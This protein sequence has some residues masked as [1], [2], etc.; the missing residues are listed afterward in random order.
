[1]KHLLGLP[2]HDGSALF[3]DSTSLALGDRVPVRV[4]VPR[5]YGETEVM[6]R[7]SHDG[8]PLKI[9]A[10]LEREDATERWYTAELPIDNPV[11]NYRWLLGRPG[12]YDW[13]TGRGVMT[14]DVADAGDFRA[15]IYPGAPDWARDAIGYQ[16]F[17]DR[18]ARS[19]ADRIRPDWAEPAAW[20]DEPAKRGR[21][22]VTQWYGGD[23]PGIA[24]RLDYVA[25][26]GVNLLYLTPF[27]PSQ[28]A[29]RYDASTFTHV[30][31]LLGGDDGL[32]ALVRAAHGRRMR[33]IGDL[34]TNHTGDSHEWFIHA[35]DNRGSVEAGFYYWLDQLPPGQRRW[36]E[37]MAEARG[38]TQATYHGR[39]I[40]YVS[41]LGVPSLP[42]LNWGSA[43]LWGRMVTGPESVVARYLAEP[44]GLDG[45]RVDVAHMTGRFAADD[46]HNAVAR[47][48]RAT[49]DA[50]GG[51]LVAEHFYDIFNDVVGDGWQSVMNY[52]AFTKPVWSWLTPA[53]T[54]QQFAD[55][56][57]PVPRRSGGDIVATMREFDA[58][59]PW[60]VFSRQWN[61]LGSH[62]T[63]RVLT[64]LGDPG[65][66]EIAMVWLFTYP[67]LPAFFAGDEGGAVGT[68]GEHSR[69]TMPWDQI[70]AGG[71]V[72]W[73]QA[74]FE[75]Y[76]AA[77]AVRQGSPALKAGSLRWVVTAD[78]AL[79]F[80]RE[81]AEER[82][83]VVLARSPWTG[84]RLPRS[85][86]GDGEPHLLYGGSLVATPALTVTDVLSIDGTGPAVGVWRLA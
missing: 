22:A 45:W 33:V 4:R 66:V 31:P 15:T 84:V 74:T 50:C 52:P 78:D 54:D 59:V 56:P 29:H 25:R 77:I 21:A 67:G 61:M 70:A 10:R 20:D 73:D 71:G 17:P 57:V 6:L 37:T 43:E 32:Q 68:T 40:D 24:E 85:I 44:F 69:V 28:S 82:V 53:D 41:W 23:L 80:L 19:D 18:F 51:L 34:T 13:L 11:V 79:V 63:A 8:D 60:S 5:D 16:I 2:H 1:M 35:Y 86:L 3:V 55:L 81:T 47:A 72:R 30:D 36:A 46:Y 49:V 9:P 76:R 7:A 58:A 42:K 48:M 39:V 12:G 64:L 14:R 26:L 27:F 38:F 65:L 83:L 62:D 75:R